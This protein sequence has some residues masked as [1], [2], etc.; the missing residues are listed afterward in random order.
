[1]EA[2]IKLTKTM[3]DKSI[4]DANKSV[5]EFLEQDFGMNY[6]DTFFTMEWYDEE[7]NTTKRN[8]FIVVGEYEDGTE[9]NVK[10]YRSAKRGDR[11]ISIQKLKQFAE[12]GDTIILTSDAESL[13]DGIHIYIEVERET[14]A[15]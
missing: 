9:S 12:V 8:G 2:K 15:A 14:V 5:R 6:D 4:I 11:R 13:H 10:F 3:L 7:T 1:M